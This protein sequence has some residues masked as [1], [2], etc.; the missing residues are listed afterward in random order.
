MSITTDDIIS[1]FERCNNNEILYSYSITETNTHKQYTLKDKL[2]IKKFDECPICLEGITSKQNA[3][4]TQC[5]HAFHKKCMHQL[6]FNNVNAS[7][8][9]CRNIHGIGPL[10]LFVDDTHRFV[11]KKEDYEFCGEFKYPRL[12][13][14]CFKIEGW[15]FNQCISCEQCNKFRFGEFRCKD[16][17]Y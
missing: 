12:C 16:L 10:N 1:V 9:I 17:S 14:E 3:Y 5:G 13:T 6:V 8:P 11:N 4:L 15:N 7:C 2:Y